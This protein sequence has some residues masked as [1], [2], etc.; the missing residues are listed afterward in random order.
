MYPFRWFDNIY[1]ILPFIIVRKGLW[2]VVLKNEFSLGKY[3]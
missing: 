1:Y 2:Q 3:C